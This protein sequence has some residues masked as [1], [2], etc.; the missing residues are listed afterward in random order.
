MIALDVLDKDV[1]TGAEDV[2]LRELRILGEL[3]GAVDAIPGRG[4]VCQ[5]CRVR[6]L[7]VKHDSQRIGRIDARDRRVVGLA[8]RDDALRR[9]DDA[10]VARL[11]IGRGQFRTVMKQHVRAQ[12][13]GVGAPVRRR[14]PG[15]GEVAD[16]LWIV[17]GVEFEKRRVVRRHDVHEDEREIGVAVVVRRLGIDRKRQDPAAVRCRRRGGAGEAWKGKQNRAAGDDQ[18]AAH[19]TP[20]CRTVDR[21]ARGLVLHCNLQRKRLWPAAS[22]SGT[23]ADRSARSASGCTA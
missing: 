8:H 1:G 15:L 11:Y 16:H 22:F 10:F 18:P 5:H 14:A 7:Q 19:R 4:E 13:E 20:A 6:P 3:R 12:L 2:R 21:R 17:G 9:V 23:E